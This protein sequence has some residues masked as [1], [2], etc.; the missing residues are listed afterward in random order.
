[1]K[2]LSILLFLVLMS[3][4][5]L[6]AETPSAESSVLP[7]VKTSPVPQPTGT[8]EK[9]GEQ[10]RRSDDLGQ[11]STAL[12]KQVGTY[13]QLLSAV[14]EMKSESRVRVE[15]AVEQERVREAWEIGR[16]IDAHVLQ[17]K[18]RADYA[19]QVLPRL[20]GDLGMS[21]REL[22]YMLKF[23]RA[24]P[25]LPSTAELSW[26]HYRELLS[27]ND[28]KERET[29]ASEAVK[30]KWS[31]KETREA[32]R[33]VKARAG[34]KATPA[35]ILTA[36]PGKPYTYRVVLART[37]GPYAGELAVDLGFSNYVRLAEVVE[38]TSPFKE[39]DVLEFS[40]EEGEVRLLNESPS[41]ET[42]AGKR[43]TSPESLLYTYRT[44]VHRVLDGDTI[45]AVVD[46]GFGITTMQ[47]LRFR[48]IDA[49]EIATRD[50][51]EAK[52]FVESV[53]ASPAGAKQSQNDGIA[54]S[55]RQP[56]ELLAMTAK[57]PVLIKTTK[58]DKYDRYLVDVFA[59]DKYVNNLLLKQG[60]A[61]RV[62][63]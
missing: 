11:S 45:E 17:H 28:P 31:E 54:A 30:N 23:Y 59:G 20:A 56:A 53:I 44:Y 6:P 7:E 21:E 25:I 14:R 1:M 4:G 47:T 15:K 52:E 36:Q 22:Y 19:K 29:V 34:E 2:T 50:G 3:P 13:D 33:K 32:V 60:L 16:L 58:S 18:E 41:T 9:R 8:A 62:E 46:L 57:F 12:V 27:V 49:P 55:S 35:E 40:E 42:S 63:E 61:V 38:D 5:L 39:G 37:G 26:G 24:Y 10:A 43:G 51:M 48:G